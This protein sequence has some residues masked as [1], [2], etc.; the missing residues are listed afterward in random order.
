MKFL[1]TAWF[2]D[3]ALSEGD[4]HYEWSACI[5][6]NAPTEREAKEWGDYLAMQRVVQSQSIYLFNATLENAGSWPRKKI[7]NVPKVDYGEQISGLQIG[8]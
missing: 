1:Y 8:W 5:M 3:T 2:R 6:I 4:N 7:Q